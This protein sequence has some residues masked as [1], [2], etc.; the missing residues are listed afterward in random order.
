M[1]FSSNHRRGGAKKCMQTA[2]GKRGNFGHAIIIR[3]AMH[4][5][6]LPHTLPSL[7]EKDI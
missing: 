4:A 1:S 3:H 2:R 6:N 7:D 5:N